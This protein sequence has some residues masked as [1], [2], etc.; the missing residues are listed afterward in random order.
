VQGKC[1][2]LEAACREEESKHW[3][4]MAKLEEKNKAT[5]F[6]YLL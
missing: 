2:K 5:V 6:L 1:D 3:M 4:K